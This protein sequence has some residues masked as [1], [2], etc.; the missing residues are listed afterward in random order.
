MCWK[1]RKKAAL[2]G[3]VFS[4]VLGTSKE[5]LDLVVNRWGMSTSNL[6]ADCLWDTNFNIIGA[7]LGGS[8]LLAG[9]ME[10][11]KVR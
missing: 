8:F 3:F 7:V 9:I 5:I 4:I 10:K 1:D 6:L 11:I 2:Y